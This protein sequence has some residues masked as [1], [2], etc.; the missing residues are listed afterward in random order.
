MW[1]TLLRGFGEDG[2]VG[3]SGGGGIDGDGSAGRRKRIELG[4]RSRGA[5]DAGIR[6]GEKA[7]GTVVVKADA[8]AGNGLAILV[9]HEHG[10]GLGQLRSR[11]SELIVAAGDGDVGGRSSN[12]VLDEEDVLEA[13]RTARDSNGG[14]GGGQLHSGTSQALGVGDHGRWAGNGTVVGGEVDGDTRDAVVVDVPGLGNDGVSEAGTGGSSLLISSVGNDLYSRAG[15]G[16]GGG[17]DSAEAAAGDS[18]GVS[19]PPLSIPFRKNLALI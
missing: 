18:Q 2:G 10:E 6:V 9:G 12:G 8:V 3:Y 19:A 13:R 7:S 11:R 15:R 14:C 16:G 5:G 4:C 17:G 1:T